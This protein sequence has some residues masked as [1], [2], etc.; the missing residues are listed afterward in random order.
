MAKGRTFLKQGVGIRDT[1]HGSLDLPVTVRKPMKK[2][3]MR[4]DGGGKVESGV[5]PALKRWWNR[6]PEAKPAPEPVAEKAP[7]ADK[8]PEFMGYAKNALLRRTRQADKYAHGGVASGARR[9]K[10][11]TK[12]SGY[13]KGGTVSRDGCAVRGLTKG[14]VR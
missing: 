6:K 11:N 14:R 5:V 8:K 9:L 2:P 3:K 12:V 13:A 10:Q 4:Y 7:V 1:K